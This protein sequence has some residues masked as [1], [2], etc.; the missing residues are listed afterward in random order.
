MSCKLME[1][2]NHLFMLFATFKYMET[3][4]DNSVNVAEKFYECGRGIELSKRTKYTA[5]GKAAAKQVLR[6]CRMANWRP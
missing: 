6:H 1:S 4:P 3:L 5:E 2:A